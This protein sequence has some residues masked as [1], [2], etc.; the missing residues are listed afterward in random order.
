MKAPPKSRPD[1]TK[2][3]RKP[4]SLVMSPHTEQE[5]SPRVFQHDIPWAEVIIESEPAVRSKA[6]FD[7]VSSWAEQGPPFPVLVGLAVVL[8]LLL[9]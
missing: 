5:H 4:A 9:W 1:Y 3:M 2:F 6:P 8:A 7:E